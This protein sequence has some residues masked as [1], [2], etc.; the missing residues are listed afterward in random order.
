MDGWR[1]VKEGWMDGGGK[2]V[3]D[4]WID[5]GWIKMGGWRMNGR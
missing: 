4:G 5:G 2:M 1:V 3:K